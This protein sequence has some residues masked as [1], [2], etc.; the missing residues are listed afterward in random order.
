MDAEYDDEQE[1]QR[2]LR[3]RDGKQAETCCR[4]PRHPAGANSRQGS[5]KYSEHDGYQGGEAGENQG[6]GEGVQ[7]NGSRR[8]LL[9]NRHPEITPHDPAE[10][11]PELHG[12]RIV[13]AQL[14]CQLGPVRRRRGWP[15]KGVD[16]VARRQFEGDKYDNRYADEYRNGRQEAP[17]QVADHS[18][19]QPG[20]SS[21][22]TNRI[23]SPR[24]CT[25]PSSMGSPL[26][27]RTRRVR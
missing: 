17:G 13:Q 25:K 7:H 10:P 9:G 24:K 27:C 21:R 22:D 3:H 23:R 15:Q 11:I 12:H 26:C 19:N 14:P 1:G 6:V 20:R 18:R 5:E 4:T 2:I 16:R 8:K